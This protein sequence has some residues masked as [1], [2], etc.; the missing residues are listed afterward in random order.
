MAYPD[1]DTRGTVTAAL[2]DVVSVLVGE[3]ATLTS[4][5]VRISAGYGVPLVFCDWRGVPSGM[6]AGFTHHSLAG[7]RQRGQIAASLSWKKRTWRALVRAKIKHTSM[8]LSYFGD[9]AGAAELR[10]AVASV[11]SGDPD[12]VEAQAARYYWSRMSAVVGD[13]TFR[14]HPGQRAGD[15][16]SALDYG[17]TV[18]RG[19]VVQAVVAAGLWPAV[20]V[21][22]DSV[23]NQW[24]LVDDLIEP[25]RAVVDRIVAD[26]VV[27]GAFVGDGL[28][29]DVRHELAGV[30]GLTFTGTGHSVLSSIRDLAT[31]YSVSVCS[32]DDVDVPKWVCD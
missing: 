4:S 9:D 32:G 17:Y 14:R 13:R 12:N 15:V 16:N 10:S 27:R 19:G 31:S 29:A 23:R 8:V 25:F 7:E 30:L 26:M 18:L 24:G 11:R 6:S 1:G 20:G 28:S 22:H 5:A 3:N 2:A 21:H